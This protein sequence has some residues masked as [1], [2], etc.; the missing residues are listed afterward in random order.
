MMLNASILSSS[1]Q[2]IYEWISDKL[3]LPV[4]ADMFRSAAVFL[5]QRPPGYVMFVAHAGRDIMNG[6]ARTFR[7]DER[8]QVQYVHLLN[9]IAPYWD[10]QWGSSSG[11]WATEEPSHHEVPH[12]I[13]VKLK[14]LI[15]EHKRGR[16]RSEENNAVFFSTFLRYDDRNSIPGNF[17]KEWKDAKRWFEG[18][19]HV[20]KSI[21]G[22]EVNAEIAK[23]FQT[24]E[25][26]LNIAAG[27]Q[28][29]RI[30][31]LDE[32]LDETNR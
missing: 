18:H 22:S 26:F 24:L 8:R 16:D 14:S 12:D 11:F 4:Y 19:A 32:I 31:E 9:D 5:N 2:R 7:G 27:S 21:F 29:E 17:M 3:Q 15:D 23:H 10:D 1:Q 25:N 13:C 30:R 6:L 20:R 28:Y